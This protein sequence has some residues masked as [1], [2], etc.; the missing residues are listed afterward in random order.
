MDMLV[1]WTQPIRAD[2]QHSLANGTRYAGVTFDDGL[3]SFLESGLPELEKR[4]IPS[5]VFVVAERLGCYPAWPGFIPDP[6]SPEQTMT[7]DQLRT[8]PTGLVSIGSHTLTH[9]TLTLLDEPRAK[10]ELRESRLLLERTLQ[11]QVRLFS[12]P[13]GALNKKLIE[14]SREAGYER[15]FTILPRMAFGTPHDFIVDRVAADPAD[16]PLEF[17]LK[18]FGAYRWLPVAFRLKATL[19]TSMMPN[20]SA[21]ATQ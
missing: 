13:H 10:S 1:R 15:V 14:W 16:W 5:T 17:F 2:A 20:R 3:V 8:L 6:D 4:K 12:F 9:P 21:L 11:R 18:L 7:A 19:R